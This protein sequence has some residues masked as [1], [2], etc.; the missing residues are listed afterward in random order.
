MKDG[1][2][3]PP[4]KPEGAGRAK[5]SSQQDLIAQLITALS[6]QGLSNAE[7]A[8]QLGTTEQNVQEVLRTS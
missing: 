1:S 7:V 4:E 2:L 8:K 5:D 6:K 3:T